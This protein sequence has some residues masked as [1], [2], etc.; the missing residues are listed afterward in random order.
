MRGRQAA[1]VVGAAIP[2]HTIVA[3]VQGSACAGVNGAVHGS[4]HVDF[5]LTYCAVAARCGL[6]FV[7]QR[8]VLAQLCQLFVCFDHPHRQQPARHRN[9][10]G[11]FRQGFVSEVRQMV[12]FYAH[13]GRA[14]CA[15]FTRQNSFQIFMRANGRLNGVASIGDDLAVRAGP[16][17]RRAICLGIQH[18][19]AELPAFYPQQGVARRKRVQ[20]HA[21]G[22][23]ETRQPLHTFQAAEK[24]SV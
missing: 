21:Q 3:Q 13:A 17:C 24:R 20:A 19:K 4:P 14:A 12:W 10:R 6:A 7:H 18:D 11:V 8:E 5:S 15:D 2:H 9:W 1:D 23:R 22:R 16:E